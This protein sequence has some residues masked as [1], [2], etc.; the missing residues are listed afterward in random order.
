[1]TTHGA[2]HCKNGL[3]HDD[4]VKNGFTH[5]DA[6]CLEPQWYATVSG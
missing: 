5:D 4:A 2:M 3:T 6:V 1:M